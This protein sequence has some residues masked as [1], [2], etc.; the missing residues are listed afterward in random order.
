MQR[1]KPP[2]TSISSEDPTQA[3]KRKPERSL[4]NPDR[5]ANCLFWAGEY[6]IITR[7]VNLRLVS[8]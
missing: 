4:Y 7:Y 1:V 3:R 6:P 8:R 2:V 5:P